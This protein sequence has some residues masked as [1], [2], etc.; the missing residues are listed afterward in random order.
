MWTT[1]TAGTSNTT[2]LLPGQ[3]LKDVK[4]F[5]NDNSLDPGGLFGLTKNY[6]ISVATPDHLTA[7]NPKVFLLTV[8]Y[9]HPCRDIV[10]NDQTIQ[11]M[12]NIVGNSAVTQTVPIF[13][14]TPSL[15]CGT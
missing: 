2:P 4:I 11:A 9:K 3:F 10:V 5:T 13:T 14:F 1:H 8:E 6:K 7:T 15:N 12:E